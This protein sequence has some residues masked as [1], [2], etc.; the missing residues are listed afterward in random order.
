[1]A[2]RISPILADSVAL[3][4]PQGQMRGASSSIFHSVTVDF[5]ADLDLNATSIVGWRLV[6]SPELNCQGNNKESSVDNEVES[7]LFDLTQVRV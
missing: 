7:H 3:D 2:F 1:M 6:E 4:I 5:L